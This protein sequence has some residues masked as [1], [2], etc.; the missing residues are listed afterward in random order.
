MTMH[1]T[2]PPSHIKGRDYLA[3]LAHA[4]YWKPGIHAEGVALVVDSIDLT[5]DAAT[6][7]AIAPDSRV[8]IIAGDVF[9]GMDRLHSLHDHYASWATLADL[10]R[11]GD[12]YNERL[13]AKGV[14]L[15][16]YVV[17]CCGSTLESRAAEAGGRWDTLATCPECGG[18]YMKISTA[19]KIEALVP[20]SEAAHG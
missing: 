1:Q 10:K 13:R 7:D 16:P 17:P 20:E 3:F 19:D 4:H 11:R 5:G 6:A 8:T 15:L 12:A 14:T 2:L 9:E 18:L